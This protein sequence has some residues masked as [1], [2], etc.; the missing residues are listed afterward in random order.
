MPR[1][2]RPLVWGLWRLACECLL[3]RDRLPGGGGCRQRS[4][5]KPGRLLSVN[6]TRIREHEQD[7]DGSDGSH[8]T[9]LA[10]NVKTAIAM[11]HGTDGETALGEQYDRLCLD[12]SSI[13]TLD[14][15]ASGWTTAWFHVS[16]MGIP[17]CARRC[18]AMHKGVRGAAI[19]APFLHCLDRRQDYL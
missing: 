8:A 3:V 13:S 1:N 16:L 7:E 2:P 14:L 9:L 19:V 15:R 6:A 4:C 5:N 10:C 12:R 18:S 17:E 11:A